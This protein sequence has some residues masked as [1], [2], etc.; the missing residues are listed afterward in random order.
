MKNKLLSNEKSWIKMRLAILA[1]GLLGLLTFSCESDVPLEVAPLTYST[2]SDST[3]FY[4]QLGWQQILDEGY[5]G[6]AEVSYRKALSFDTSFLLGQSVL[7]R[8]TLDTAERRSLYES[9]KAGR[10]L[11]QGAEGQLLDVFTA[12]TDYTIL[13]AEDPEAAQAKRADVLLL[14]EEKLR[15]IRRYNPNITYIES[16]Y[17]EFLHANHGAAL[18]LDSLD[19]FRKESKRDNPFLAG[20][21]AQLLA[22][23]GRFDE[24]LLIAEDLASYY[25]LLQVPK[26]AVVFAHL[27]FG[28]DSLTTAQYYIDQAVALDDRNLE[29]TRLQTQ[30]ETAIAKQK[31][32]SPTH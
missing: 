21:K 13:R 24:A 10:S 5:Y 6:P 4:Y 16:E 3:R 25:Q 8:L 27:Y 28:M 7:A 1:F 9:V 32:K 11:L 31:A 26:P 15:E 18:A 23:L 30:I 17:I 22:E 12:L 20:Y 2:G 29:A 19:I 14:A